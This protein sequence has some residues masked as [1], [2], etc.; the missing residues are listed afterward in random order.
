MIKKVERIR[1]LKEAAAIY[2]KVPVLDR[3]IKEISESD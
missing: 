2:F 1:I 3:L